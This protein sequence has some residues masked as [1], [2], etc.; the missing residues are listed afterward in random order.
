MATLALGALGAAAGGAL[1]PAGL[2]ILGATITGAAIG[3]Q[4]GALAG[5]QIDQALFGASGRGR[6]VDGPRLSDLHVT[7]STEG[8]PI[9]RLY[10]RARLGGQV[11]WATDLEE[12]AIA[13]DSASG[14]GKGAR[15]SGSAGSDYRYFANF[16]VA[17]TEGEITALGRVF[18]DGREIDLSKFTFRLYTGSETQAPDA[19]IEAHEGTDAA[20]AYLGLAYIVFERLP[21]ADFGN[22]IPQL[23][24]EVTRAVDSVEK[25]IRGV[26]LIPGSGEFVYASTPVT[27]RTGRISRFAEN[28]NTQQGATDFVVAI[29]QLQA[30]L[31][32]AKSVSLVVSWFGSDLRASHCQLQPCVDSADKVTDPV[33]WSVAGLTRD[34]ARLVSLIEGQA[35]YG[36]TPSDQTVVEAIRHLTA[37]GLDVTLSPFILMDIPSGNALADPYS[38]ATTQPAFPWRGRITVSPAAGLAGTPDKTTAA[39]AQLVS[40]IGTAQPA[41]FSIVGDAVVYSG[42]VEWS[43]RRMIL[44]HAFLAKAAGGVAAFVLCSELR[45]LTQV[46]DSASSYPFVTALIQLAADVRGILGATTKILYAADWTEYFGHQPADASGDVFFHLDPLWASSD[47]D[48]IGIDAYWPLADWRDGNTHLDA[49]AGA[50]GIHDLAYLKSNLAAGEGYNWYYASSANRDAQLRTP[51]TD[52]AYGKPWIYR[53]KDLRSWWL[54]AH[55]NRPAGVESATPTAW[56]PQSKP[57]WLMEIGCPAIDKGANQPNVFIDPKSAESFKPYYSSGVRDDFMQRRYLQA[58][59]EGFDPAHAGYVAD[60]NPVSSVTGQ[61]M[62]DI[63]HAHVYAW[64]ARPY[65]AFPDLTKVWGDGGNWRLGHWITGRAASAP[66]PAL[67]SQIL[68][69][70]GF[71]DFD[72][73]AIIGTA[74]GFVIDRIMSVRDALQPLELAFFFDAVES[75]GR[76]VFRPRSAAQPTMALVVDDLVESRPG[77]DLLRLTRSQE[78][79]LPSSAKITYIGASGTYAQAVAESRRLVGASERVSNAALPV[80]LD[81][82]QAGAIAESWLLETW[83]SRERASFTVPPSRLRIEPGDVVDVT[84]GTRTHTFRITEIGEHGARDIDAR[85]TDA[86]VYQVSAAP[87]RALPSPSPTPA[88]PA[89]AIFLD[90]PVLDAA[91]PAHTG[92]IAAAQEPWPG[93]LAVYR[94][95]DGA[96]F[97]LNTIL[98]TPSITGITL[99]K[100]AI[101]PE[102]RIDHAHSLTV[103]LDRGALGSVTE[104][105]LLA[106]ANLVALET[107]PGV[108]ELIQFATAT[109]IGPATYRLSGL[110]RG[111]RGSDDALAASVAPGARLVLLDASVVPVTLARDDVAIAYTWKIGPATRDLGDPSYRMDVHA[112]RGRGLQPLSPVHIR[113]TRNTAGDLA[114]S[115]I[116][117]TRSGGDSWDTLEVSLGEDVERYEVD[118]L[119]GVSV[120]RTLESLTSNV[121]YAAAEQTTDFGAPQSSITLRVVQI[122]PSVGRGIPRAATV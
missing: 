98:A 73:S 107:A 38:T 119:D 48:A 74:P 79:D 96:G 85:A 62:L 77:S 61:R 1:L 53:S 47:I 120:K 78:T 16:A 9:P 10:G 76:I 20:P 99:S 68:T 18:A 105:Q 55:H 89:L 87:S 11:I 24:F 54:N 84:N 43:F 80:V 57:F 113:A 17:L 114:L 97:A 110:L 42:P 13:R 83:V 56:A 4:L 108:W 44:H 116:R 58:I 8:A 70:Y 52:G 50:T 25:D 100:L 23:S 37:E 106:G 122:N 27:R 7:T 31:P 103:E 21:L 29:D 41:H 39:A 63:A 46:R 32:N 19:L 51:I 71:A 104:L 2:S 67:I 65:P 86:S 88:G 6:Q 40:F 59:L 30:T 45:G 5:S 22:R 82:E 12:E 112:F 33:S 66:L 101:A 28:T 95:P 118:I 72:A 111:Q 102:S 117:R 90:I 115:W 93:P 109:L 35:A 49:I 15:G 3:S 14:G 64:D 34:E 69:D 92:Y 81:A 94:S 26:S 36:G 121:V 91:D 75:D 60:L